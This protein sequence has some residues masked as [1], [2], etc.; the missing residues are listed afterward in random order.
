MSLQTTLVYFQNQSTSALPLNPNGERYWRMVKILIEDVPNQL[1]QLFRS[2]FHAKY[3]VSWIER[4]SSG[5]MFMAKVPQSK[6]RDKNITATVENGVTGDFDCTTLFF[7]LLFS[8]TGL[9]TPVVRQKAQ[10]GPPF[11]DSE[12]ID[13]LREQRNAVAHATT[14]SITE[15]DFNTRIQEIEDIYTDLHWDK[16]EFRKAA[17]GRLWP[18]EYTRLEQKIEVEKAR[19]DDHEQQLQGHTQQLT[20]H[21]H[22]LQGHTHRFQSHHQRLQNLEQQ[23]GISAQCNGVVLVF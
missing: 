1:R 17:S 11:Y 18:T 10:R 5:K 19:I 7:C 6:K 14:P 12:R 9:L 8:G 2:A 13:Q 4:S 15:A 16:S 3:M 22:Q 21:D 20:G 23:S